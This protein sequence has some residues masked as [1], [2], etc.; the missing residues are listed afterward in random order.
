MSN[1]FRLFSSNHSMIELIA[2]TAPEENIPSKNHEYSIGV[3]K[4]VFVGEKTNNPRKNPP[5]TEKHIGHV[6]TPCINLKMCEIND[7][8]NSEK[9][10]TVSLIPE[11]IELNT[12][13]FINP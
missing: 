13:M 12:I 9:N 1:Q 2:H 10:L 5:H 7:T 3:P 4:Y 8:F 11:K 6:I